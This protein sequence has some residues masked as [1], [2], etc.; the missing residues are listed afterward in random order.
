MKSNTMIIASAFFH[1]V[2][3]II[4]LAYNFP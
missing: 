1:I 2:H 4:F 3:K